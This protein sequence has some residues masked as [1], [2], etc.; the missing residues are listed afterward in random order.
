MINRFISSLVAQS[1]TFHRLGTIGLQKAL[2]RRARLAPGKLSSERLAPRR[3]H[4]RKIALAATRL[5]FI[6]LIAAFYCAQMI[7][8]ANLSLT[9]PSYLAGAMAAGVLTAIGPGVFGWYTSMKRRRGG[10][11]WLDG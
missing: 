5:G 1:S 6:A 4:Q 10:A 7:V 2:V 9:F 8:V 11:S 3:V